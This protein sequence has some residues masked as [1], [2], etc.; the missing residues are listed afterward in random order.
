MKNFNEFI[1]EEYNR[2][3]VELT[4]KHNPN[5]K[6]S[7]DVEGGIVKNI[8][9]PNG[10]RFLFD[11]GQR[12]NRNIETWCCSNNYLLDGEDTCPDKIHGIRKKDIPKGDPLRYIYP[13]KFR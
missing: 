8:S 4:H 12:Y 6:I 2:R 1:N 7:F 10:I 11:E 3:S 9:N 5:L 13:N